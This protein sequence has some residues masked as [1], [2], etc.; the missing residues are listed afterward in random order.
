MRGGA[1]TYDSTA[2]RVGAEIALDRNGPNVV[3]G[4]RLARTPDLLVQ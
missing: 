3:I 1:W 4:F 2:L